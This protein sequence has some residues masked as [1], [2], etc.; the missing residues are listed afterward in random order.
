[1]TNECTDSNTCR[2]FVALPDDSDDAVIDST[3]T[4]RRRSDKRQPNGQRQSDITKKGHRPGNDVYVDRS[5]PGIRYSRDDQQLQES[6]QSSQ[7]RSAVSVLNLVSRQESKTVVNERAQHLGRHSFELSTGSG[8]DEVTV[9]EV[10]SHGLHAYKRCAFSER[11]AID[12]R[13]ER[14]NNHDMF[15][16]TLPETRSCFTATSNG[17]Y[18][19]TE[20]NVTNYEAMPS[21][22][23]QQ[24]NVDVIFGQDSHLPISDYNIHSEKHDNSQELEQ[25][26]VAA[27]ICDPSMAD[28]D[29][30]KERAYSEVAEIGEGTTESDDQ[31]HTDCN[32]TR[33]SVPT[34]SANTESQAHDE[35]AHPSTSIALNRCADH[36][37]VDSKTWTTTYRSM[38]RR[39]MAPVNADIAQTEMSPDSHPNASD[40]ITYGGGSVQI[41]HPRGQSQKPPPQEHSMMNLDMHERQLT[42]PL[43]S[44]LSRKLPQ[45]QQHTHT[46]QHEWLV[47]ETPDEP[48][49]KL[50][51]QQ[52]NMTT[53]C[54]HLQNDGEEANLYPDSHHQSQLPKQAVQQQL[55]EQQQQRKQCLQPRQQQVQPNNPD[56]HQQRPIESSA[57]DRANTSPTTVAATAS[58]ADIALECKAQVDATHYQTTSPTPVLPGTALQVNKA[59][60]NT[61]IQSNRNPDILTTS[62]P[63]EVALPEQNGIDDSKIMNVQRVIYEE[64][65][66]R[67]A[68]PD[69][70]KASDESAV[71]ELDSSLSRSSTDTDS[72]PDVAIMAANSISRSRNSDEENNDIQSPPFVSIFSSSPFDSSQPTTGNRPNDPLSAAFLTV[73]DG[74]RETKGRIKL[75]RQRW[76]KTDEF[77]SKCESSHDVDTKARRSVSFS[78]P[79]QSTVIGNRQDRRCE[80][81]CGKH[82]PSNVTDV[83]VTTCLNAT[84]PD[85][86]SHPESVVNG[87]R[88][89]SITAASKQRLDHVRLVNEPQLESAPIM[90]DQLL[91]LRPLVD[92]QCLEPV[93]TNQ[94]QGSMPVSRKY[95]SG[96]TSDVNEQKLDLPTVIE[97]Q[98]PASAHPCNEHDLEAITTRVERLCQLWEDINVTNSM[99]NKVTPPHWQK[100]LQCIK[101]GLQENATV[102]KAAQSR[103][104]SNDRVGDLTTPYQH[105]SGW[106]ECHSRRLVRPVDKMNRRDPTQPQSMCSTMA[107]SIANSLV[108]MRSTTIPS[109]RSSDDDGQALEAIASIEAAQIN[110]TDRID[111]STGA[112]PCSQLRLSPTKSEPSP[113]RNHRPV[114]QR[115]A[116]RLATL[117]KNCSADKNSGDKTSSIGV[118][119]PTKE[120]SGYRHIMPLNSCS[121]DKKYPLRCSQTN[122][123]LT[124]EVHKMYD[125]LAN[126]KTATAS[127]DLLDVSPVDSGNHLHG[128]V[129]PMEDDDMRQS[130]YRTFPSPPLRKVKMCRPLHPTQQGGIAKT[131]IVGNVRRAGPN[132]D[133]K[134]SCSP[135]RNH[136]RDDVSQDTHVTYARGCSRTIA[137]SHPSTPHGHK[138]PS[139]S[140]SQ[141][142]TCLYQTNGVEALAIGTHGIGRPPFTK[143]VQSI[144]RP[145]CVDKHI[146][147]QETFLDGGKTCQSETQPESFS[148]I[149]DYAQDTQGNKSQIDI[150]NI[151]ERQTTA[152]SQCKAPVELDDENN[153]HRHDTFE[154][155]LSP[156][157]NT[158]GELY[159]K[160][161]SPSGK[162]KRQSPVPFSHDSSSGEPVQRKSSWQKHR[163]KCSRARKSSKAVYVNQSTTDTTTDDRSTDRMASPVSRDMKC[164][165]RKPYSKRTYK[166]RGKNNMGPSPVLRPKSDDASTT[167]GESMEENVDSNVPWSAT[168]TTGRN[169]N[170]ALDSRKSP[171]IGDIF[172]SVYANETRLDYKNSQT[173]RNSDPS[174]RTVEREDTNAVSGTMEVN[175]ADHIGVDACQ[176]AARIT[177]ADPDCVH[178]EHEHVCPEPS[179]AGGRWTSPVLHVHPLGQT[180]SEAELRPRRVQSHPQTYTPPTLGEKR[181][182][183]V[184]RKRVS[185]RASS[186]V[187]IGMSQSSSFVDSERL[188]VYEKVLDE[189][190]NHPICRRYA[191]RRDRTGNSVGAPITTGRVTSHI[192][193]GNVCRNSTSHTRKVSK[194]NVD[195]TVCSNIVQHIKKHRLFKVAAV[196]DAVE[197]ESTDGRFNQ[198]P[199]LAREMPP[200]LTTTVEAAT[201]QRVVPKDMMADL[202]AHTMFRERGAINKVG[203]STAAAKRPSG[204]PSDP[205]RT[206]RPSYAATHQSNQRDSYEDAY[207][208]AAKIL[209]DEIDGPTLNIREKP[210]TVA[211]VGNSGRRLI[212]ADTC[213]RLG[214]E[215]APTS[216]GRGMQISRQK[217][218]RRPT[219]LCKKTSDGQYRGRMLSI[220]RATRQVDAQQGRCRALPTSQATRQVVAPPLGTSQSGQPVVVDAAYLHSSHRLKNYDTITY[221]L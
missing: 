73:V 103:G 91:Q 80:H 54:P 142:Y 41:I 158:N 154:I 105:V 116:V 210:P 195:G 168:T 136:L 68:A 86:S 50:H 183:K 104:D 16:Q 163:R 211:T 113:D 131:L 170:V 30:I 184:A 133:T 192:N 132:L 200:E 180:P 52:T 108:R 130:T 164:S 97:K 172:Q 28:S 13:I 32:W 77:V 43:N 160:S 85:E 37:P 70:R 6:T 128:Y 205:A 65:H 101:T 96:S 218:T 141:Q 159:E 10:H 95:H 78:H 185:E 84:F 201:E 138:Q 122:E 72:R 62:I 7:H 134:Q 197:R 69:D 63:R 171:N 181:S 17:K 186:R 61:A 147:H 140:P 148:T 3:G 56:Q 46:Q 194:G 55:P 125:C 71:E 137:V 40:A 151:K 64:I 221:I 74:F 161:S 4:S 24:R 152:D 127:R 149:S 47:Q 39:F 135:K 203:R 94:P 90:T 83:L 82:T 191:E 102:P 217:P 156:Y 143:S 111:A 38:V 18:V 2:T 107:K 99:D 126:Q 44:C 22:V 87:Q 36:Q 196:T 48:A 1:M 207:D 214:V 129:D 98:R 75:I 204:L 31:R 209:L 120:E 79:D 57:A 169:G 100:A 177:S 88:L 179:I 23:N 213:R 118:R 150:G 208:I 178:F 220:T 162:G 51:H 173:D 8:H 15:S 12:T 198:A 124:S 27:G 42:Q 33:P 176:L 188:S 34:R 117:R 146:S 81:S 119:I 144:R 165:S 25:A 216:C 121:I 193:N 53:L 93:A 89:E 123:E 11:G 139:R 182:L 60:S 189:I 187:L 190:R 115:T 110:P 175:N 167:V 199:G 67:M 45:H 58:A 106:T 92:E 112:P 219:T 20:R 29:R 202:K 14:T 9:V 157:D 49:S 109:S 76:D 35:R 66:N 114:D 59:R 21:A 212:R 155:T 5:D 145:S 26:G 174:G 19:Q 215:R 206:R 166:K 153:Y